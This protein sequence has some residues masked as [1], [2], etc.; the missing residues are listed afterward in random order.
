[1]VRCICI[2][3]VLL[4]ICSQ[5]IAE[6]L[7]KIKPGSDLVAAR[8]ILKKHGL[9]IASENSRLQLV[10]RDPSRMLDFC[11]LDER[12]T[13]VCEYQKATNKLLSICAVIIPDS[14][15]KSER[16]NYQLNLLEIR[17]GEDR[18][19]WLKLKRNEGPKDRP[20]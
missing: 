15:P 4:C 10:A 8:A 9:E 11:R 5:S 18:T 14:E 3:C 19:Y 20:Q 6:E 7:D 13:L 2:T 16:C 17:F 12:T 1:M